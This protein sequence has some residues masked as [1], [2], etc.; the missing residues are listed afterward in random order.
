METFCNTPAA[1]TLLLW[2][3]RCTVSWPAFLVAEILIKANKIYSAQWNL[4][5]NI[6]FQKFVPEHM[7]VAG[8][9]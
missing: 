6:S 9:L 5:A 4:S 3:L 7:V 8:L 1:L 2:D